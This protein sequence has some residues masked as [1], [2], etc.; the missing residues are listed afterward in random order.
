MADPKCKSCNRPYS[1]CLV[2]E[3]SAKTDSVRPLVHIGDVSQKDYNDVVDKL[4]VAMTECKVHRELWHEESVRTLAFTA[5]VLDVLQFDNTDD[6]WWRRASPDAKS[7]PIKFFIKCSDTFAYA[8]ADLEEI[9]PE[10][11]D[12][13]E[14]TFAYVKAVSKLGDCYASI[15]WVARVRKQKPLAL[16]MERNLSD[17]ELD[18]LRPLFDLVEAT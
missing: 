15:L 7:G 14:Q 8:C 13:L 12:L 4:H 9:T 10:N 17:P 18:G 16:W 6:L 5:R 1:E 11:I 3:Y 2:S